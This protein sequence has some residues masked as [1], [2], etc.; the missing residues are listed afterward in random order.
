MKHIFPLVGL[1][2]AAWPAV[3]IA[4]EIYLEEFPGWHKDTF[5]DGR[6]SYHR[7]DVLRNHGLSLEAYPIS[8]KPIETEEQIKSWI[9]A[10][11]GQV[12]SSHPALCDGIKDAI[13]KP[14]GMGF[15]IQDDD[16]KPKCSLFVSGNPERRP[17]ATLWLDR[18]GFA[19]MRTPY[20][21]TAT[22]WLTLNAERVE[23][24][25]KGTFVDLPA[26]QVAA[27][28]TEFNDVVKL[29][30]SLHSP[31]SFIVLRQ[32]ET[33][34]HDEIYK[35]VA[36]YDDDELTNCSNWDPSFYR[37]SDLPK[38]YAKAY[39]SPRNVDCKVFPTRMNEDSGKREI[40]VAGKWQDLSR[41]GL[42]INNKKNSALDV[43]YAY[44]PDVELEPFA[45]GERINFTGGSK[46]RLYAHHRGADIETLE[47]SDGWF[48]PDGRYTAGALGLTNIHRDA[49]EQSAGNYYLN[50][51]LAIIKRDDGIIMVALAGKI[52]EDEKISKLLIGGNSFDAVVED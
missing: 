42:T 28:A 33:T 50:G 40:Q 5:D 36:I 18:G 39:P 21:Q 12:V 44:L 34:G 32:P 46:K 20:Q 10:M 4:Q 35:A 52:I 41:D 48:T 24:K 13:A 43:T 25:P 9:N 45:P 49:S 27:K 14:N 8:K 47:R 6:I 29:L 3:G 15:E 51:N 17:F 7:H 37:P 1:L 23:G 11:V 2:L 16:R 26:G 30:T 38:I 31:E 22:V 19:R